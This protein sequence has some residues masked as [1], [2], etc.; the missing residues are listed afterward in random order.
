VTIG[1][2]DQPCGIAVPCIQIFGAA[3]QSTSLTVMRLVFSQLAAD[4]RKTSACSAG[5]DLPATRSSFPFAHQAQK[6]ICARPSQT[7]LVSR[8][9]V[10]SEVRD[11]EDGFD[12]KPDNPEAVVPPRVISCTKSRKARTLAGGK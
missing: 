10:M 4:G 12:W 2:S 5:T 11:Y 6:L 9:G 7:G 3:A 1:C 8:F